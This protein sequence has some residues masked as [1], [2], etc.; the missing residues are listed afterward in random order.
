[1]TLAAC[2]SGARRARGGAVPPRVA[3]VL[4]AGLGSRLGARAGERPKGLVEVAGETL[5]GRTLRLLRA[6]GVERC[7]V[8]TGHRADA[9]RA[10]LGRS[11]GVELVH[12]PDYADTGTMASLARALAR[13][14][15]DFVLIESDLFYEARALDALLASPHVDAILASGPTG[16]GDEVYLEAK[17]GRVVRVSKQRAEISAVAG[18]LVGISRISRGL[19]DDL[20]A[21]QRARIAAC[22]HDRH[23][24]DTD[25]L[26][27]A[28]REREIHLLCIADLLWSELDDERHWQ[29][30]IG[31]IAPAIAERERAAR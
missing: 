17:D 25:L 24:Y 7:V 15:E 2:A 5:V 31:E 27:A 30:L 18:E 8:V 4:A 26:D 21:L 10:A 23:S 22:G 9:Y 28:A 11:T 3:I 1:V 14:D 16:A 13:V 6:R 12:N 19:A 20:L 29:R